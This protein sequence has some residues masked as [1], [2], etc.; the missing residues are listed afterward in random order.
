MERKKDRHLRQLKS[1]NE[2]KVASGIVD[3]KIS[4]SLFLPVGLPIMQHGL[5]SKHQTPVAGRL[6]I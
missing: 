6:F 4:I 5:T 3:E 1:K 2:K